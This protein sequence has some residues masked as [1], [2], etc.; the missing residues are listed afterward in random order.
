MLQRLTCMCVYVY[1]LYRMV[2]P[3][4]GQILIDGVNIQSLG[5]RHLR[6]K[7]R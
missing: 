1:A 6:S 4:S 5:V 2:E 7:M 3:S